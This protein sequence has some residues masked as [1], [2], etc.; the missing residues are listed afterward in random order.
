MANWNTHTCDGMSQQFLKNGESRGTVPMKLLKGNGGIAPSRYLDCK[1]HLIKI[2][3]ER[4]MMRN[5][6]VQCGKGGKIGDNIKDLPIR[7]SPKCV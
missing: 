3:R 7:I 5:H 2:P 1:P 6:R 4:C